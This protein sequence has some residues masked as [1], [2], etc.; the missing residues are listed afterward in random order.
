MEEK[1][2]ALQAYTPI[3][4]GRVKE[5]RKL[6]EVALKLGHSPIAIALAW[7]L[8]RSPIVIPIPKTERKEHLREILEALEVK[9]PEWALKELG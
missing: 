1:G 3:E 8:H 6:N 2:I 5:D 4:R 7:L 9:L